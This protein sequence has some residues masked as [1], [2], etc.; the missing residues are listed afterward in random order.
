[1]ANHVIQLFKIVFPNDGNLDITTLCF[2]KKTY[3]V[4]NFMLTFSSSVLRFKEWN[5]ENPRLFPLKKRVRLSCFT[6][7]R[8]EG[9]FAEYCDILLSCQ[10]SPI[11]V[12]RVTL[13][14]CDGKH[15][16][17]HSATGT[18]CYSNAVAMFLI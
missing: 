2:T 5:K 9:S 15:C 13:C 11:Y 16:R 17:W 10:C 4:L 12:R 7:L 8:C 3:F 14:K 18:L 6:C 1:M